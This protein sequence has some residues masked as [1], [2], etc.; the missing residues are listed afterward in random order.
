MSSDDRFL[1]CAYR[2]A[3]A[4]AGAA[5]PPLPA[6]ASKQQ[7]AAKI[8]PDSCKNQGQHTDNQT[9]Q[10]WFYSVP[11]Q[12][13]Q[14]LCG[15]RTYPKITKTRPRRLKDEALMPSESI[16][17]SEWTV[18][19]S[20]E[21]FWTLWALRGRSRG[22]PEASRGRS[23]SARGGLGEPPGRL[24]ESPGPLLAALSTQ[25]IGPE[26]KTAT[27]LKLMTL[28]ALLLCF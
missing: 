8:K 24:W 20:P 23:G 15:Q 26:A 6:T 7:T 27:C 17:S 25:N 11:F 4:A 19:S 21:L 18:L 3:A 22:A 9:K 2:A 12:R 16:W 14:A 10:D 1:N 5:L 28:I 13:F